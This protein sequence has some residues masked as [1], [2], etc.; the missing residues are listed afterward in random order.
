[1]PMDEDDDET[2]VGPSN[3]KKQ[4]LGEVVSQKNRF[5]LELLTEF[6][7]EN[8]TTLPRV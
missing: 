5:F 4:K 8:G 7:I 3:P 1:M 6:F 2:E